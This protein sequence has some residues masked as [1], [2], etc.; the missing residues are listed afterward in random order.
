MSLLITPS[1]VW[2]CPNC[3][4]EAITHKPEA[5]R[6]HHCRGLRGLYAPLVP[7]GTKVKVTANE[8]E[9]YIGTEDVQ[10]D[11]AGRPIM[12]VVTERS[13]GSNDV[14]VFAATANAKGETF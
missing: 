2:N 9:D 11:A 13:D 8:R 14:A 7:A 6:F 10:Y 1:T 5:N 4:V 3:K 12:S